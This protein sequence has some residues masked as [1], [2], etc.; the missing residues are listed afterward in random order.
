MKQMSTILWISLVIILAFG[1]LNRNSLFKKSPKNMTN[2]HANFQTDTNDILTRI[3]LKNKFEKLGLGES[4]DEFESMLRNEIRLITSISNT[5]SIELGQSKIGGQPDLPKG[6]DWFKENNDKSLSFIAQINLSEIHPFDKDN[7]LPDSGI[8]YFFYSAEQDAWG[9]DPKD[10]DKF[11]VYYSSGT[12]NLTKHEFPSDLPDYSRFNECKLD[13]KTTVGLPSWEN[14]FVQ[15]NLSEKEI[16]QYLN[17]PQDYRI[18][19]MLG[20]ANNI[21][22][23]MELDC[24][25]VTNGLYCGDPSGYNDPK[26]KDLEKGAKDWILLL[27]IDSEDEKT[28][29]MWGD[30]GRLYFW[31]KK[32]DLKNKDFTK[33]WMILQCS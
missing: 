18:N 17:L 3:E 22:S 21:Q 1:F 8:I 9:F 20:Y 4:W 11:K 24:Q 2:N 31:I 15:K 14:D 29:M 10:K 19:K 7:L 23:E 26:A 12:D 30:V 25:L 32:D 5:E 16:D 6:V 27:Q 33:T 13:I 28:G